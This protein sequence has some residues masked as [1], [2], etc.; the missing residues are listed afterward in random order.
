[1]S[2][3]G[4]AR[5]R[6]ALNSRMHIGHERTRM[7]AIDIE[8][9]RTLLL[10]LAL[11]EPNITHCF[12]LLT[13]TSLTEDIEI[14]VQG[15]PTSDD[16]KQHVNKHFRVFCADAVKCMYIYGFVP[17]HPHKLPSGDIVPAVLPHGT[18][19]WGVHGYD[20]DAKNHKSKH[21]TPQKEKTSGDSGMPPATSARWAHLDIPRHENESKQVQHRVFLTHAD[22]DPDDVFIFDIVSPDLNI[23]QS[24]NM[25]ATVPSPLSHILIDYKNLRDAQIRRSLADAWNTTARIFTSCVPPNNITNEPTHSYLYYETGSERSRLNQGLH[26]ME[27]RHRELEQQIIQPST[28][29]PS[30]YNLPIHHKLEQLHALTPCEDL[31]FLLDKYQRDVAALLGIPHDVAYGQSKVGD[32]GSATHAVEMNTQAFSNTVQNK[33]RNLED[34]VHSAYCTIYECDNVDVEVSFT[35]MPRLDIR[36]IDDVKTLFDIGAI[37]PDV[38]AQLS[39]ILLFSHKTNI[40]GKKHKTTRNATEYLANLSN[41]TKATNPPKPP[42]K[43][44]AK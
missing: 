20:C 4:D 18:F 6:H 24:S 41:I 9:S 33:C 32:S 28:H 3:R 38:T 5:G 27:G 25:Y 1:M 30:L 12:N 39:E 17:W 31:S 43:P 37:T 44:V 14:T 26:Y 42:T 23:N 19:T 40:T 16:F 13:S 29:K 35:P 2:S 22:I 15:K 7:R 8:E 34:L 21:V 10:E 11:Y 36:S